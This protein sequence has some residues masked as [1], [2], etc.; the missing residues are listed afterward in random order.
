MLKNLPKR[1][2]S[3]VL[4]IGLAIFSTGLRY[5]LVVR[6]KLNRTNFYKRSGRAPKIF[7]NKILGL[8]KFLQESFLL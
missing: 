4:D 8:L 7:R 3:F 6:T 1:L 5:K 2:F